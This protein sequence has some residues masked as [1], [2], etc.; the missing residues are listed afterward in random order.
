MS[1][2]RPV[3]LASIDDLRGAARA[4]DDLWWRSELT[5]P[6]IRAELIAQWVERFAPRAEFR[7]LAVEVDG[8]WVAALP[9]V[10]HKLGRFVGAGVMPGNE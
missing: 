5:M 6:T 9:L 7:A 3:Q 2:P 4:W 1:Q 8:Q 10:P